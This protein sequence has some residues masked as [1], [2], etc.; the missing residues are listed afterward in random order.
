VL[1]KILYAGSNNTSYQQA[2]GD[3]DHL[4]EL[5]VSA[6]QIRRLCKRIGDERVA[7]RDAAVAAYQAL[8][9][10]QR[11]SAPAGVV[12]PALAAVSVDG[13]RV[14]IFERP[15][16]G[17][18]A[19][20]ASAEAPQPDVL[21]AAT[22]GPAVLAPGAASD[23]PAAAEDGKLSAEAAAGNAAAA[24]AAD[25]EEDEQRRGRF[26]REDKV[27]V[28]MPMHSAVSAQDPC[29]QIPETFL[30]PA[31]MTT[32]VRELKKR[33]PPQEDAAKPTEDPHVGDEALRE[34]PQRWKP[35]E[36][37][38]K[39]VVATRRSWEQFGPMVA[40]AA[41][42]LGF[43]AAARKAFVADGAENNWTLHRQLFSSF[44]PILDFIH[45]LSYVFASALAG[46]G[47]K[48]GWPV[49]ERWIQWVWSGSVEK[50]IAELAVR[51]AELGSPTKD[52]P[53]G[54]PRAIVARALTYLQN[55]KGR[56]RYAEY[57][58]Q[59][60]P[61]TSSYVESA[62]KQINYRVK[63]TEKFWNEEGAEELL[64]LRADYLSDGG[65]MEAFWERR[66]DSETGQNRYRRAG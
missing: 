51:Q 55:N 61:I 18:A 32:L 30:N 65:I 54:S 56:M 38:A 22:A 1:S 11:K 48:E 7:Q 53:E 19:E 35:P 45:G 64:Q 25:E 2:H 29:P 47:F 23:A 39:Q 58:R 14:Q 8:P 50:V 44:V 6:K 20:Q 13:G 16:G 46:R 59:G 5:D 24:V 3:L 28:L 62:V 9:L 12:P 37:Q 17:A 63:G 57:R 21:V 4:A 66:E 33:A 42:A 10:A 60:L 40:A 49:Y 36:V 34:N 41:W 26:W 15:P 52:E 27:G 31:R 43:F